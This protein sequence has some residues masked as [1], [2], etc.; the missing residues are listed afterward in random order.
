MRSNISAHPRSCASLT[1][2]GTVLCVLF[3]GIG[4]QDGTEAVIVDLLVVGH[5]ELAP[6][7]LALGALQL[8]LYYRLG[9]IEFGE[10]FHEVFVD[11]VVD[12]GQ[13]QGAALDLLEDGPVGFEVLDGCRRSV[14]R[15]G[16][17]RS[18]FGN[19]T[20][21]NIPL[22]ANDFSIWWDFVSNLACETASRL[23]AAAFGG[24]VLGRELS[25][26]LKVVGLVSFEVGRHLLGAFH[27]SANEV[28]FSH[29][30][31][32]IW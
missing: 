11:F 17:K 29:G 7:L 21:A 5:Q 20:E 30:C 32:V 6:P 31:G 26:L 22:T 1:E 15:R 18:A 28:L 16:A 4:S 14:R 23:G 25:H 24:V 27:G 2:D 9:W 3:L 12:L 13:A 19:G 10:V 8:V